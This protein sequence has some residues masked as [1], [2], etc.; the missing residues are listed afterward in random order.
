MAEIIDEAKAKTINKYP[1]AVLV[2]IICSLLTVF[3][4]KSF[5]SS[6]D[7]IKDCL[8]RQEKTDKRIEV[9]ESQIYQYVNTILHKDATEKE[10]KE[11]IKHQGAELKSLKGGSQ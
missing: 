3:I 4:N 11:V 10:L 6:D 2:G 5:D 7:R 9:L 8:D 1:L